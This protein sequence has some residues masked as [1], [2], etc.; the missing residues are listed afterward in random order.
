M[1]AF[2]ARRIPLT[3]VH[4]PTGTTWALARGLRQAAAPDPSSPGLVRGLEQE[5]AFHLAAGHAVAFGAGPVALA[6]LLAALA[7]PPGA[8]I[9]LPAIAA[10]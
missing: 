9:A 8:G 2:T 3:A 6:G 10:P 7:L 1:S 5:A 4:W